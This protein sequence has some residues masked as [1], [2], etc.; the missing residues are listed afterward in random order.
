MKIGNHFDPLPDMGRKTYA[1]RFGE[2]VV[3][4]HDLPA[5]VFDFTFKGFGN[6]SEKSRVRNRLARFPIDKGLWSDPDAVGSY[7]KRK[8]EVCKASVFSPVF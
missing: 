8:I 4:W 6:N 5:K 7:L 3:L 1:E 2:A